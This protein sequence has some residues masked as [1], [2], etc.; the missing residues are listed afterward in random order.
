MKQSKVAVVTVTYGNRWRFLS[1]VLDSVVRD[2]HLEKVVVVDNASTNKKE[3]EQ[4][5]ENHPGKVIVIRNEKNI[6][7]AGGFNQSLT[8]AR[9][10]DCDYVLLLDDD[11]VPEDG[12]IGNFLETLKFFP[13]NKAV[14]L[15]NR[16]N[17]PRNEDFFY[18]RTIKNDSIRGT[19]FEVLSLPKLMHFLKMFFDLQTKDQHRR[20]FVPLAPT[21]AFVYGG[22]FIPIEAVRKASLPDASLVL[23]GDDVEYSWNIKKAGYCSYLCASPRIHDVDLTFGK[24]SHIFGLFLPETKPFKVYY[25]IRNMVLL[26]VRHSPQ[27]KPV[28]FISIALWVL[29]LFI[30]GLFKV[31]PTTIFF[32]RTLLILQAVLAGYFVKMRIPQE[33]MLP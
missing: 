26:S 20:L 14:L 16:F 31:G 21:E 8:K 33:A 5:V 27:P 22:A 29:G 30:L 1:K 18:Q 23:Y 7:S 24:G 10:L 13:D 4:Y 12:A 9:E 11:N 15:G 28:L 17:I 2:I 32:K 25:R 6:G 3:I 19:F